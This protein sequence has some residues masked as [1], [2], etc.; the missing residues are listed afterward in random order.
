MLST[1]NLLAHWKYQKRR[2]LSNQTYQLVAD[3]PRSPEEYR[4]GNIN[5]IHPY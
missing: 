3:T 2:N 5:T 4:T 1:K